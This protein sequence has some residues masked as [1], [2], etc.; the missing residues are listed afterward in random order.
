[1]D[2]S[3]SHARSVPGGPGDLLDVDALVEHLGDHEAH[4]GAE[5]GTKIIEQL[6]S[7]KRQSF[8]HI[9]TC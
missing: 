2:L 7:G 6:D 1:M 8:T 3:L 9:V 5:I 4:G